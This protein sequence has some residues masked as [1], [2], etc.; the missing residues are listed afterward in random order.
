MNV[1]SDVDWV[2][3][4]DAVAVSLLSRYGDCANLVCEDAVENDELSGD[5]GDGDGDVPCEL[6]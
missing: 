3:D 2:C 4:G 1:Q 6:C 5:D